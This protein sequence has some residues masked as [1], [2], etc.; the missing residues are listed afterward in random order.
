MHD[1]FPAT[2]E[3]LPRLLDLME[4]EG[5]LGV[6]LEAGRTEQDREEGIRRWNTRTAA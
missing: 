4:A 3:A 5:L 2:I 6:P 1:R